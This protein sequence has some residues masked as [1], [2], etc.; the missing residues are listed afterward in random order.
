MN[1]LSGLTFAK[2]QW[3]EF[4][5]Q[6]KCFSE[7]EHF[8]HDTAVKERHTQSIN[9]QTQVHTHTHGR[10]QANTQTY[11]TAHHNA[12]STF[13][14]QVGGWKRGAHPSLLFFQI[15]SW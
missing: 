12:H 7:K 15:K 3:F 4:L 8:C 11:N 5:K 13:H 10:A 14:W 9:I 2:M 6:L 1:L